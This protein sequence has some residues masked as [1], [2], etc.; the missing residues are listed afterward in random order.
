M[1][2]TQFILLGLIILI[3]SLIWE[4]FHFPLYYD[5]TGLIFLVVSYKNKTHKWIN[6]PKHFDYLIIILLGIFISVLIEGINLNLG[7]WA[8]K[9]AMPIIFGL[10]I[11][12][13]LQLFITA[14]ISLFIFRKIMFIFR[15]I[16]PL[17]QQYYSCR[18]FFFR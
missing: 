3:L 4:F 16:N 12:P 6:N 7:R 13:L 18:V 15:K 17:K 2:K 14:I 1:K 11:S 5:L 9:E 10:G 8:Y